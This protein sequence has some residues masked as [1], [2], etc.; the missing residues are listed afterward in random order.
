MS[1]WTRVARTLDGQSLAPHHEVVL[2]GVV[3]AGHGVAEERLDA[4]SP[5]STSFVEEAEAFEHPLGRAELLRVLLRICS[6]PPRGGAPEGVV[7]EE[8]DLHRRGEREAAAPGRTAAASGGALELAGAGGRD[9]VGGDLDRAGHV[10]ARSAGPSP[11]ATGSSSS[12]GHD[13]RRDRAP[14][15]SSRTVSTAVTLSAAPARRRLGRSAAAADERRRGGVEARRAGRRA[16]VALAAVAGP[17]LGA[18]PA[19]VADG[20]TEVGRISRYSGA[21]VLPAR[22]RRRR[23]AACAP[24]SSAARPRRRRPPGAAAARCSRPTRSGTPTSARCRCIRSRR[25]GWRTWAGRPGGCTPT[26]AT[27]AVPSRTGSRT[28]S[29]TTATPTSTVAFEYDDESDPGPYPFGPDIP[30][31]GRQ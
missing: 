31:R 16:E 6:A 28:P 14:R 4:P 18:R 23:R 29:S 24:S 5:R 19:C 17:G 9:R 25:R 20:S 7:V 15:T 1:S 27:R 3:E 22:R 30:V 2:L 21:D 10:G 12:A 13:R 8:R 26:S 11:A